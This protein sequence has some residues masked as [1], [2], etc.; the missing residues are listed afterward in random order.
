MNESFIVIQSGEI[1]ILFLI[2][3]KNV[4]FIE[5]KTNFPYYQVVIID[6]LVFLFF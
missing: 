6:K 4:R 1:I 5:C 3:K 2:K